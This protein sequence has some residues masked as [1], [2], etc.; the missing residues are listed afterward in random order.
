M[1]RG[2]AFGDEER[3]DPAALAD[4]RD[5]GSHAFPD[6]FEEREIGGAG[7]VPVFGIAHH[8][9]ENVLAW[10][11][12]DHGRVPDAGGNVDDLIGHVVYLQHRRAGRDVGRLLGAGDVAQQPR[13]DDEGADVDGAE[14]GEEQRASCH[15]FVSCVSAGRPGG[16]APP[17]G[18]TAQR[19]RRGAHCRA[20]MTCTT[21]TIRDRLPAARSR[22]CSGVGDTA[23]VC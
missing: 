9:I 14:R 8:E 22:P 19:L 10:R 20:P 16:R 21:S 1:G 5:V 4:E 15:R 2:V 7:Q 13:E 3:I 18:R 6:G 17:P 23:L 12:L 11:E